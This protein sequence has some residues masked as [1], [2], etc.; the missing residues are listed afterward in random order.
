MTVLW[1]E[2]IQTDGEVLVNWSDT[3]IKNRTDKVLL[4]DV[5]IPPDRNIIRKK[6]ETK[7]KYEFLQVRNMKCF[8]IPV[9]PGTTGIVSKGL[10]YL[11]TIPGKHSVDF[12]QKKKSCT[13][14]IAHNKESAT[15]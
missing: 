2:G 14:G 13:R 10:K 7:L 1:N 9:N 15:V 5:A 4:I 3:G 6:A 11:E 12:L 8:V